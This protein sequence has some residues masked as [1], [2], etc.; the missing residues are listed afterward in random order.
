SETADRQVRVGLGAVGG[1]G[2]GSLEVFPRGSAL[3]AL[4]AQ[5]AAQE[6]QPG[7]GG[8]GDEGGGGEALGAVGIAGGGGGQGARRHGLGGLRQAGAQRPQQQVVGPRDVG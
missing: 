2:D 8:K 3:L 4:Q 7:V 1:E 6:P 5:A